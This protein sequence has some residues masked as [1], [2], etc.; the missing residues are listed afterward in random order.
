MPCKHDVSL[1]VQCVYCEVENVI[2]R[3]CGDR[4]CRYNNNVVGTNTRCRCDDCLECGR[5]TRRTNKEARHAVWC[6]RGRRE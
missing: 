3:N 1:L 4:G 5:D 6:T 2:K